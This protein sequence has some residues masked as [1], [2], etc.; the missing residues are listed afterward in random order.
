M[1][2]AF[3]KA[4]VVEDVHQPAQYLHAVGGALLADLVPRAPE[5]D[6]RMIPVA[7]DEIHHVALGPFLEVL[8]IALGH[9][10]DGPLVEHLVHDQEAEAI[11]QVEKL[12][13][14]RVVRGADGVGAHRLQ[15]L[16]PAAPHRLR[17]GRAEAARVVVEVDAPHLQPAAVEH[18]ATILVV[19]DGA[20]AERR[21]NQVGAATAVGDGGMERVQ[22]R[23]VH[24]PEPRRID[25]Q[26][27]LELDRAAGVERER[28]LRPGDL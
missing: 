5:H 26:P 10:A 28:R 9:L 2:R 6:R 1:S 7:A 8:V 19:G 12:R 23:R 24:R 13:R 3:R 22:R 15:R 14:R 17:H 21:D 27:L 20:D 16:Q 18:E 25:L 11:A 4:S